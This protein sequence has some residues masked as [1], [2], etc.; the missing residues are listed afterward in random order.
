MNMWPLMITTLA[1]DLRQFFLPPPQA[2]R[3]GPRGKVWQTAGSLVA[4]S[5]E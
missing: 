1:A 5:S 2:N 4:G 3:L